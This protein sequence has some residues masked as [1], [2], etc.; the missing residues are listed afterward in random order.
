MATL[1]VEPPPL[2]SDG[3]TTR[4]PRRYAFWHS[5]GS[6]QFIA[7]PMVDQSERAFR[8]L[9]RRHG[10]H[11]CYTPMLHATA[12]AHDVSAYRAKHV[13]WTRGRHSDGGPLFVQLGGSSADDLIA[14]A[15]AID[16]ASDG[17]VDAICLNLGCP[18]ACARKGRYGAFM[19]GSAEGEAAAL[20]T[21]AAWASTLQCGVSVKIR[22]FSD[23]RGVPGSGVQRSVKLCVALV[24]AGADVITVHARTRR[25]TR[26][27]TGA[28]DWDALRAIVDA[29]GHLVPI[30]S[31]GGIGDARDIVRC[32]AETGVAGV[33]SAEALLENPALFRPLRVIERAI[34]A[35]RERRRG[36]ARRGSLG[37][38]S[39]TIPRCDGRRLLRQCAL[40]AEYL[41]CVAADP[42]LLEPRK[43]CKAHVYRMLFSALRAVGREHDLAAASSV[44][45]VKAVVKAVRDELMQRASAEEAGLRWYDRHR[46]AGDV[47]ELKALRTAWI[48]SGSGGRVPS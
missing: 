48:K 1:S 9:C 12:F 3:F 17:A 18:E 30:I 7:S 4:R 10:A 26:K 45:G 6:P 40:A 34:R 20:A 43:T 22:L 36:T 14:A 44:E 28:S 39:V 16:A 35:Y 47:R 19:M 37:G 25:Q 33:M 8:T 5:I 11:V 46:R 23:D 32:L 24:D 27:H 21:V 41:A 31:N 29:V 2:M 15:Q 13:D 38:S 42:P